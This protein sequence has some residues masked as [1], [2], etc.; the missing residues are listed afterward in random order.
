M[1][2]VSTHLKE[3]A[4]IFV[5]GWVRI[6]ANPEMKGLFLSSLR[7]HCFF[8]LFCSGKKKGLTRI[9]FHRDGKTQTASILPHA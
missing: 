3:L 2:I 8:C 1:M 7:H 5:C 4:T 6:P 9:E